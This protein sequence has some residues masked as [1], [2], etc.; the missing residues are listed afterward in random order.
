MAEVLKLG[1]IG[2]GIGKSLAPRLHPFLGSLHKLTVTYTLFDSQGVS[3]YDPV[4]V[5]NQR[6]QDGFVGVNVT[7]PF[8]RTVRSHVQVEDARI[9]RIGSVNTVRL[10]A[11]GWPATNTDFTGFLR[12][13]RHC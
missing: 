3:G 6:A 4:A 7:Y 8:K 13:Y 9:A 1:L 5:V 10:Q 12:A 11:P 2:M